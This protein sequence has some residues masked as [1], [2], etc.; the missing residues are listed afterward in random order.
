[1]AGTLYTYPENFRAYKVLIA[2]QYSGAAVKE[3][4]DFVFGET[5]RSDAFLAK[6]PLGKVPAFETKDGKYLTESN[7]IAYYVANEQ[8]RGAND[9]H[10]AEVQSFVSFADNELLPAVQ[11]WVFPVIGIVPYNKNNVE[12][13]KEDLRRG[14][15][16]LNA[17]LLKQTFL[18]GE[19]VTLADV[20][21]FT[22]LL[23]AYEH[24]LDP[25]FRAPFSAVT[26]WFTTIQNQPQVKAVVKTFTLCAKI[27]Q[28]D[29]KKY[30]EFQAKLGGGSAP[31]ADK[32]EKKKEKKEKKP[33]AEEPAEQPD[34]AEELLAAEPKQNDPFETLPKGTFNF[35]DFKRFYSNEEEA[36]SIPYFWTK[37]DPA[38]YSIWYGEYKYPEELTKV[39]MSCNL[40]TGMFQRLDKMRKQSFASVCL[41]GEDNNSTI[42]GI[43]VWRGQDLAFQLSPDWQVDY[44]VYDW[45]KLDPASE[46]TKKLVAQYFSW[47]GTDKNGRKFN[48]GKIFK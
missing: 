23:H 15:A 36:K 28:V 4:S 37:F 31:A 19:R 39:F 18:V 10:R 21:V 6:F 7:A 8:L 30:A 43:W 47:T 9:F 26:R 3:A 22:T 24:V 1:M 33:A 45:K 13:A 14:L 11:S 20:V 34:A 32:P 5:N 46:E 48:Q 44:E 29:P 27:A 35:D 40:I 25:S 17:R 12:R 41:F 16:V 42:S 2:A 38:N